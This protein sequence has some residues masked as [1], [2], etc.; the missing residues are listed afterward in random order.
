MEVGVNEFFTVIIFDVI[1]YCFSQCE[2][3]YFRQRDALRMTFLFFIFFNR[4]LR[5]YA[6]LF[7]HRLVLKKNKLLYSKIEQCLICFAEL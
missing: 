5:N 3:S 6:F 7:E 1:C 4:I 2:Q